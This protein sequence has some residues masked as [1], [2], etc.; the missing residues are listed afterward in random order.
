MCHALVNLSMGFKDTTKSKN[1][2]MSKH[3]K[4]SID[5]SD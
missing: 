1:A 3:I 2:I 4:L 5:R